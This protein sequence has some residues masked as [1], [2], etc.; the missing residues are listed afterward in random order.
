MPPSPANERGAPSGSSA[1]LASLAAGASVTSPVSA[2]SPAS[3]A[4]GVR[5][6]SAPAPRWFV[7]VALLF[8]WKVGPFL[9]ELLAAAGAVWLCYLVRCPGKWKR[10]GGYA[11]VVFWQME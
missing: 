9:V 11:N 8:G 10:I 1:P 6:A 7:W 4:L 2:A 3:V 5:H